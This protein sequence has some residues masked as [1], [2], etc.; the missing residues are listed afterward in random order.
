MKAYGGVDVHTQIHTNIDLGI[1]FP[2]Y[3]SI[4]VAVS[5]G[6]TNAYAS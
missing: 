3:V 2:R 6:N 5:A 1:L 4:Y